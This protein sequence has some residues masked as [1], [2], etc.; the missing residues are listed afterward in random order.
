MFDHLVLKQPLCLSV[1]ILSSTDPYD[2]LLKNESFKLTDMHDCVE[3]VRHIATNSLTTLA[4]LESMKFTVEFSEEF[5]YY[6]KIQLLSYDAS[7]TYYQTRSESLF[8]MFKTKDQQT[9]LLIETINAYFLLNSII[10]RKEKHSKL[11]VT[12]SICLK[13]F[14]EEYLQVEFEK[15]PF[16][17]AKESLTNELKA[18]LK[19]CKTLRDEE[20]NEQCNFC[21]G[22]LNGGRIC[23]NNH[24]TVRCSI[25]KL[26]LPLSSKTICS[27]CQCCINDLT[28]LKEITKKTEFFCIFCDRRL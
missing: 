6:L 23:N 15:D 11:V 1:N 12:S 16:K 26:Q 19:K 28:I 10:S 17:T 2:M 22:K 27:N 4:P 8:E 13:K 3:A 5:L 25:T 21:Q 9:R 7:M 14:I 18:L 24:S 20:T